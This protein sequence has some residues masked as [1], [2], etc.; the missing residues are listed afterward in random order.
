MLYTRLYSLHDLKIYTRQYGLVQNCS[1]S[2]ADALEILQSYTKL[3]AYG[4]Q[5]Q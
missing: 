4:T 5:N 1:V 3:L 2:S